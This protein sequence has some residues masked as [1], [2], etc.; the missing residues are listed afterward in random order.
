MSRSTTLSQ[1]SSMKAAVSNDRDLNAIEVVFAL[2][3]ENFAWYDL[4]Y[5]DTAV[6]I[7]YLQFAYSFEQGIGDNEGGI[8]GPFQFGRLA[9][10]EAGHG[11]WAINSIDLSYS[12]RAAL[13]YYFLNKKR[14]A[15]K[16]GTEFTKEI[17]YL[18]HNQG[19]S[20]AAH[21]LRTGELKF[22]GQSIAATKLFETLR[23]I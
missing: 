21:L 7:D 13:R 18:Y 17:A 10:K 5:V 23:V 4:D 20:G 11:E 3:A 8:R 15:R 6:L 12:T 2:E 19:P 16:F 14:H 22:G 1:W 9:W